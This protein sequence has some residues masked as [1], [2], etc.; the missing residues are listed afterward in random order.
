MNWELL[1]PLLITTCVAIGGWIVGHRLNIARDRD[2]KHREIRLEYLIEAYSALENFAGRKPPFAT[3]IVESL[4]RA[5]A[6]IQLFGTKSQ[7]DQLERCFADKR[8]GGSG[9]IN[10]VIEKL[11]ADLRSEL[12]L[13]K[14]CGHVTWVRIDR[15]W[16]IPRD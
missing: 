5:I 11:R 16:E 4:E 15:H 14:L 8:G 12:G 13:T 10:P 2:S 7:I 9:D 1:T 6:S 3:D